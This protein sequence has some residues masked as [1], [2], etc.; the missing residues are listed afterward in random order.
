MSNDK[1]VSTKNKK[2]KSIS[3]IKKED[4]IKFFKHIFN[5][6]KTLFNKIY[7]IVLNFLKLHWDLIL[8]NIIIFI[9]TVFIESQYLYNLKLLV[10]FSNTILYIVIPTLI[11]TMFRPI[12]SKD[13]FISIPILY[14]LFLFFL[15]YCTIR[16]LY[17]ISSL[18]LDKTPNYIDALM[19]VFVFTTFEYITSF[20]VNKIKD[21]KKND[22]NYEVNNKKISNK[23]NKKNK[24]NNETKKVNSKNKKIKK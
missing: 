4:C 2:N 7:P 8:M 5:K 1:K 21:K 6:T 23:K 12:K 24:I 20:I 9:L 3:K 19:V 13:I 14:I 22:K 11:F 15:D 18:G 17:G 16:E 10:W